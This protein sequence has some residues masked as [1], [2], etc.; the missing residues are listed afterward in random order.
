[1]DSKAFA[2]N[3][4]ASYKPGSIY[5]MDYTQGASDFTEADITIR[6]IQVDG[7]SGSFGSPMSFETRFINIFQ[8][9]K[10]P[11]IKTDDL[12]NTWS[13][14]PMDW[15]QNQLNFAVWCATTGC[16]VSAQDHLSADVEPLMW[17]LYRFHVYFQMWRILAEMSAPLPQDEAW[18][19]TSNP[20]D[21]WAYERIANEFGVSPN[22]NWHVQGPQLRPRKGLLL[23]RGPLHA[24]LRA[25]QRKRL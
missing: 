1:M 3:S 7:S 11:L 5:P 22:A 25:S 4:E 13:S 21:R 9:Y 23:C 15:W 18:N 6:A 16:D 24:C 8:K 19:P 12:I 20:Y 2:F 17:S 14:A 10:M